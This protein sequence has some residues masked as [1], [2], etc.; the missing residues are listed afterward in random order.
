MWNAQRGGVS[1]GMRCCI[2]AVNDEAASAIQCGL[3]LSLSARRAVVGS[4][5]FAKSGSAG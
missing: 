2:K 3:E 4:V 1:N 5:M